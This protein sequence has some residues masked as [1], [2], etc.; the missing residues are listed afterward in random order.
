MNS[1]WLSPDADPA[2]LEPALA[3]G[4]ELGARLVL[5]AGN[6]PDERRLSD[7]LARL[8]LIAQN[9]RLEI[10]FEFMPFTEV[11]SFEQALRIMRQVAQPNLRLLIDA[12][13]VSRSGKD[14]RAID[15]L[16]SSVVSYVH[17]CDAPARMPPPESLARRSAPRPPLSRRRRTRAR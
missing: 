4:A 1:V 13:H 3:T 16:D 10:A 11:R 15:K 8:A 17:L 7:N 6:D 2:K 9:Y 5:V 12:L 14:L